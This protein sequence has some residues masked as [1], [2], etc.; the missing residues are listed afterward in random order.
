MSWSSHRHLYFTSRV[1]HL[2]PCSGKTSLTLWRSNATPGS[3]SAAVQNPDGRS[4]T[5]L[6]PSHGRGCPA[7]RDWRLP[8]WIHRQGQQRPV[9]ASPP[10]PPKQW[11]ITSPLTRAVTPRAASRWRSPWWRVAGN[12]W[13]DAAIP[14]QNQ[15]ST[16]FCLL[17]NP[18]SDSDRSKTRSDK[19][20]SLTYNGH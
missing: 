18:T 4:W 11:G 8:R 12:G 10:L 14:Q 2:C 9:S 6:P 3:T 13:R 1:G 16:S 5:E 17:K 7:T 19:S 20:T 15:T